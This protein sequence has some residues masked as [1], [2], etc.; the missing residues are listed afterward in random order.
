MRTMI[1][2]R[3]QRKRVNSETELQLTSLLD[4]LV[5]ILVF[6]LK[7]YSA[8]TN[9]FT[10]LPGMELPLSG[11]VDI[12]SDSLHVIVTKEG[13]TFE[14][15]RVLDFKANMQSIHFNNQDL[16]ENG[17]R[18]LPLFAA[19]TEA[20]QQS[21]VLRSKSTVKD[22]EGH[23]LQFDGILAIQADKRVQYDVIKKVM[24]TAA[25]A[26]YKVFHFLALQK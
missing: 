8:S 22:T 24:Y 15:K 9:N 21:E 25:S 16:D 10:T 26:Q 1:R 2:H 3:R 12:P 7:T 5:I 18:I 13:I 20:R 4:I 17:R 23:S 14:G 19:L 6:L 11:S